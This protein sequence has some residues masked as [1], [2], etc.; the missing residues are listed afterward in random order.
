MRT[1]LPIWRTELEQFKP[2]SHLFGQTVVVADVVPS[3]RYSFF[4][5]FFFSSHLQQCFFPLTSPELS[6]FYSS[7]PGSHSGHFSPVPATVRASIFVA[8][9]VQY[10][11]PSST[12]VERCVNTLLGAFCHILSFWHKQ[13]KVPWAHI[14]SRAID[15]T[16]LIIANPPG[17][18]ALHLRGA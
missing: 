15:L 1:S 14:V 9:I 2:V 3:P 18:T 16:Y 17:G 7:N 10:F 8:R 12:R 6:P 11:L 13:E 4:F 5:F